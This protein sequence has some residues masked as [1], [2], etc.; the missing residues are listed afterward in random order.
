MRRTTSI[1]LAAV[2]AAVAI[3]AASARR[4][5]SSEEVFEAIAEWFETLARALA[6]ERRRRRR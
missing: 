2:A 3:D 6:A 5:A 1:A 4:G